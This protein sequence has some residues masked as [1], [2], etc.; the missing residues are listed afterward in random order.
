[1]K[2]NSKYEQGDNCSSPEEEVTVTF[3][4]WNI[5]ELYSLFA[6]LHTIIRCGRNFVV[7]EQPLN[8]GQKFWKKLCFVLLPRGTQ[9]EVESLKKN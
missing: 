1:L 9:Q 4:Y 8:D 7:I 2:D 3:C 5:I 6:H